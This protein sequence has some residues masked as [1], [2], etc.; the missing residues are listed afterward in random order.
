AGCSYVTNSSQVGLAW[1][2]T[3]TDIVIRYYRMRGYNVHD[4]PGYDCHGLPVEVMIEKSLKLG[5]KKDIENVV[6]VGRFI[7]DCRKLAEEN[8]QAQTRVLKNLGIWMDWD[9]PYLTYK[10][11]YIE[12]VWW[13]IKQAEEKHMV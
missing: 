6:G 5:S 11:S 1:N 8:V 3:M 10:D 4:Q 12:S 13:T 2:K 7:A 9:N